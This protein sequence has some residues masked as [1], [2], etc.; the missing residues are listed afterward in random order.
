MC[1]YEVCTDVYA[2]T[3]L[4]LTSDFLRIYATKYKILRLIHEMT[5]LD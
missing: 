4:H 5:V 3:H 2:H 1:I